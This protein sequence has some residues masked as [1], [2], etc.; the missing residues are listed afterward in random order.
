MRR[1]WLTASAFLATALISVASQ[2]NG[3]A[4]K[5]SQAGRV[6]QMLGDTEI[7]IRYS[8][9][10]AR[11]RELFGNLVPWGNVWAPGAD[12]ATTISFSDQ[13]LFGGERL[14][15]GKY[16]IWMIPDPVSWTVIISNVPDVYHTR[17]AEGQDALRLYVEPEMGMHMETLTF[18]FPVVDGP[19]AVLA[20]HWGET[21]IRVPIE[22][23]LE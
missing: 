12:S 7:E 17:Y 14:P 22:I 5:F 4:I 1:I 18:H 2:A 11:G 9:P 16:S 10:V 20:F 23:E 6:T 15:A 3:Q 13:V 21:V 19:N 8:R